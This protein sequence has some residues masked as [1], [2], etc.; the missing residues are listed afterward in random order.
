MLHA[1]CVNPDVA[2]SPERLC[3]WYGIRIDR[4]HRIVDEFARCGIVRSA[5]GGERGYRWNDALDWAVPCTPAAQRVVQERWAAGA[6]RTV[7][8]YGVG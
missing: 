5:Q 2:W 6:R 1:F 3:T 4:A 7:V 8:G